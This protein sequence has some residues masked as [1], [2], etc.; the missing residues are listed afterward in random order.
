MRRGKV[1]ELIHNPVW[2]LYLHECSVE[3]QFRAI[4]DLLR[5]FNAYK[6]LNFIQPGPDVYPVI[7]NCSL[8]VV[9]TTTILLGARNRP[10]SQAFLILPG[11]V[12]SITQ[13]KPKGTAEHD[14][15]LLEYLDDIIGTAVF[16][17]PIETTLAEVDRLAE[18]RGRWPDCGS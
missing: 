10:H 2:Y 15:R 12:E 8:I 5:S 13:M 17:V 14:D 3:V 16:N 1:S 7:Q 11:E 6:S 4:V 9:L 18:E